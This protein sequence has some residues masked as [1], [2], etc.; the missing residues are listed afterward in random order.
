[1]TLTLTVHF[2]TLPASADNEFTSGLSNVGSLTL[3]LLLSICTQ[4][5]FLPSKFQSC[6][7][8]AEVKIARHI[9]PKNVLGTMGGLDG[10]TIDCLGFPCEMSPNMIHS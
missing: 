7:S 3:I 5:L 8:H 1:M 4:Y 2:D 6:P 10:S 9:E